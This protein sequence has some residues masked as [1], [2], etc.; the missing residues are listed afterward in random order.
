VGDKHK[1]SILDLAL[2][3]NSRDVVTG[4]SDGT[5]VVWNLDNGAGHTLRNAHEGAVTAVTLAAADRLLISASRDG[6]LAVFD[7]N[8]DNRLTGFRA[9][10][11]LTCCATDPTGTALVAGDRSGRVHILRFEGSVRFKQ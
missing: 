4:S 8:G 7:L 2:T 3:R 10:D 6:Y 5:I 9:D 11:P 1:A